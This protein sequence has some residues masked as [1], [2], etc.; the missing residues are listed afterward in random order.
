MTAV[1]ASSTATAAISASATANNTVLGSSYSVGAYLDEV[2]ING[3]ALTNAT[4][5]A[6]A[7]MT[8]VAASSTAMTAVA[9]SSTAMTAVVASST[10][11][12]AI[13]NS[14]TALTAVSASST[15][16]STITGNAA[17]LTMTGINS[18]STPASIGFTGNAIIV[19][20]S[21]SWSNSSGTN[22]TIGNL[23]A[24]T[25]IS[26]TETNSA[27]Y[28]A[29]AN[30]PVN[31]WVLPALSTATQTNTAGGI[32]SVLNIGYLYV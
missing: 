7:T 12:L 30:V 29:I 9:A 22:M 11:R 16:I 6:Q 23:R 20:L 4:L 14:D 26:G 28:N 27:S 18:T 3:G 19:K 32:G 5:R 1:A 15:A 17:Y 2:A 21:Q 24:G 10:A 25:G 31:T 13:Y 8:A